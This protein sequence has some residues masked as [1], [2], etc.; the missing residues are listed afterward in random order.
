MGRLDPQQQHTTVQLQSGGAGKYC[1]HRSAWCKQPLPLPF[2]A[3]RCGTCSGWH[4]PSP[5]LPW[6]SATAEALLEPTRFLKP[7]S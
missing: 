4:A 5:P 1:R 2:W 6:S 3:V 7:I